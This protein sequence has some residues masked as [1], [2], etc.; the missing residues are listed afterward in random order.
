M[1]PT[2]IVKSAVKHESVDKR[3][4]KEEIEKMGGFWSCVQA[5]MG[6][7]PGDPDIVACINGR[8]VAIECKTPV[9][10]LSNKQKNCR[11][12]VKEAGGIYMVARSKDEFLEAIS[13]N[14][15]VKTD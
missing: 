7:K 8:Y 5:G 1:P 14:G 11:E 2:Y 3:A 4:I 10:R 13:L 6:S 12:H 15:L 9:G